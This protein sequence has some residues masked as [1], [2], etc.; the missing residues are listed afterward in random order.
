MKIQLLSDLH[1]EIY[2]FDVKI[3]PQVDVLVL[4]GDIHNILILESYL[5]NLRKL[6]EIPIILV[7]GNHEYYNN[8]IENTEAIFTNIKI[9]NIYPLH[10]SSVIINGITF[11]GTTLW[12]DIPSTEYNTIKHIIRDYSAI[13]INNRLL[14]PYD[15]NKKFREQYDWLINSLKSVNGPTVVITHHMPSFQCIASKYKDCKYNY[16]YAS[17]LD[18]I[19]KIYK[20]ILWLHGHTHS[21]VNI[22]IDKTNIICNPA[23]YKRND[24]SQENENFDPSIII[25]I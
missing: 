20:P 8:S 10:M 21:S 13:T 1:N 25:N 16:A 11:L 19:I 24:N 5:L 6:T 22:S 14:Q 4:A 17:D 3:N 15:I 7:L 12:S 23:G 9:P 18:S 2:P